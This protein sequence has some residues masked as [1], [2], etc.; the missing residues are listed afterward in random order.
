MY[1]YKDT[2]HATALRKMTSEASASQHDP[3]WKIAPFVD[4]P[5]QYGPK[6]YFYE[7]EREWRHIGTLDFKETD[8]AFLIIPEDLHSHARGFFNNAEAENTGPNYR[9]VFI[10]PYWDAGKVKAAFHDAKA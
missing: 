4:Q 7:W 8:A 6:S 9:C 5:G 3:I 2:P 1:A 10:D